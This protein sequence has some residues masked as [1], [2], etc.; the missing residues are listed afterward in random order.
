MKDEMTSIFIHGLD[1]SSRGTKGSWLR[2]NFPNM[3]LPDFDGSLS[4]RLEKLQC[5]TA[6]HEDLI[7]IGSSYGGL[8]AAAFA[9]ERPWQV[10]RLILLAPALNFPEFTS[11]P[12]SACPVPTLM[13]LGRRDT[14]CP[15]FAVLPAACCRFT[16][17]SI[18]QADEDHLLHKTFAAI[19]WE[20]MLADAHPACLLEPTES[21]PGPSPQ[22]VEYAAP[23][24][25]ERL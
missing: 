25:Q 9:I 3:L 12:A 18:H 4:E 21:L 2:Q 7:M 17:L 19:D 24:K 16:N 13:Y 6:G 5:I 11:Y 1:S 10:K 20:A 23:I 8:M 14:V 22:E 15:P